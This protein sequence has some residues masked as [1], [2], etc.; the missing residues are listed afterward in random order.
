V[1]ALAEGVVSE[2][3]ISRR[4]RAATADGALFVPSA[5]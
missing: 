1:R 4:P 3:G 2:R 5:T